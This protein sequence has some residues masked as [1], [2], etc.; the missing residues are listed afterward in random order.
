MKTVETL[1]NCH[2]ANFSSKD[3]TEKEDPDWFVPDV[4][5]DICEWGR[6]IGGNGG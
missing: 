6:L 3:V 2:R 1:G 4:A 5:E